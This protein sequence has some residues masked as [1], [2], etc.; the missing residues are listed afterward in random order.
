MAASGG[1]MIR[2]HETAASPSGLFTRAAWERELESTYGVLPRWTRSAEERDRRWLEWVQAEA[3]GLSMHLGRLKRPGTAQRLAMPI[4][5]LL[6][7]LA[8]DAAW[9]QERI[10]GR[11]REAA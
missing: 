1:L 2:H 7:E 3:V 11:I 5:T 6:D 9:A 10:T 4:D 8:R